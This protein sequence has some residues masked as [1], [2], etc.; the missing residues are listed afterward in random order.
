MILFWLVMFYRLSRRKD[1]GELW[2]RSIFPIHETA[3]RAGEKAAIAFHEAKSHLASV[4]GACHLLLFV[5]FA[6]IALFTGFTHQE[7]FE[8][9]E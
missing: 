8:V 4:F 6:G 3:P 5:T 9:L 7:I 2:A 1:F